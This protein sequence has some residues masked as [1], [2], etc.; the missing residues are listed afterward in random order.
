MDRLGLE[1]HGGALR[2]GMAHYNTLDEIERV[3]TSL[4]QMG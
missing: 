2:L 4:E 3:L 1:E